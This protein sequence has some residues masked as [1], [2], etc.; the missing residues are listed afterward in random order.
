MLRRVL[1]AFRLAARD[2]Q[3][4][5]VFGAALALVII[6]TAA[7]SLG[8]G[9]NVVDGLYFAV[10]TLNTT[11]VADPSLVLEHRWTK[12]FTVLY[13]LVGI[14]VLVEMLR[15]LGIA[16]VAVQAAEKEKHADSKHGRAAS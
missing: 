16:F 10:S 8:E 7:Y 1:R 14:G 12:I 4:G 2:A 15:R 11:S 9:W 3:F 5:P 13:L 6:G